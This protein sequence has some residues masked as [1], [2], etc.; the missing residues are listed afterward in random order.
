M[1]NLSCYIVALQ[2]T[3]N[4]SLKNSESIILYLA[5]L[6]Y[7]LSLMASVEFYSSK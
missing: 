6:G 7:Q 3:L 1:F 2:F 4:G 5:S